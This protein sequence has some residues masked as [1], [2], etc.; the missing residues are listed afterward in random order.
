[1][2][3]VGLMSGTS[4]DGVDVAL[5]Q[6]EGSG[7]GV[8][9]RLLAFRTF[10]YSQAEREAL[11]ALVRPGDAD[12][13][14]LCAAHAWL[15][16]CFAKAVQ[17]I[18]QSVSVACEEMDLIACHGHTVWHQPG[19]TDFAGTPV[20]GT[21]QIGDPAVLAEAL[22]CPVVS[23]FRAAD[24]AAGGQ[25]APL[26]TYLDWAMLSH[27]ERSRACQNLGG[28][29][30]V[31]FLPAGGAVEQVI[32]FDTG[33]GNALIDE[34]ARHFSGGS[35][36][37]DRDGAMAAR[38]RVNHS[39]LSELLAHPYLAQRPPKSTGREEFGA[40]FFRQFQERS[41]WTSLPPD[42]FLATLTAFT[43]R[44]VAEAY[45]AFLPGYPDEVIVS[46]GGAEN[47]TL[48]RMLGNELPGVLIARSDQFG[49]SS[50]AKEAIAFAL[51]G[52]ET[53]R[54]VPSNVPSAT[55]ARGPRVLGRVTPGRI[56][57]P[58]PP[59]IERG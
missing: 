33:P 25:G 46:G 30:N 32:A 28:I 12:A 4:A 50:E 53:L 54:G 21:L 19:Q 8:R 29:G 35:L 11:L 52:A 7:R 18:C 57:R 37:F 27:A 22:G 26:V 16:A 14:R 49:V 36:P 55:G 9:I 40:P 58:S 34:A 1:M 3:V 38:G 13:E 24:M 56:A 17:G 20:R 47:P 10:P 39:L 5:C 44:S 51:L 6:I 59:F 42:D 2:K 48:L 31:T 23:D 41:E 45:R 43:A 15:G